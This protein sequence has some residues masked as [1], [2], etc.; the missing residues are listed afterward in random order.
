[1]AASPTPH[2]LSQRFSEYLRG[3]CRVKPGR[4][5]LLACSGGPD[6]MVLAHLLHQIGQPF[7]MAHAQFGLRGQDSAADEVLVRQTAE[8]W[9]LPFYRTALDAA[10][11]ANSGPDSLQMAARD[12]R[13]AWLESIRSAHGYHCIATAHHAD[14]TAE[15]LYMRL[16]TGS[17]L[18]G[19]RGIRPK[20]DRLVRPLLFARKQELL[21]YATAHEV[22]WREDRSN[23]EADYLRNRVRREALPQ[24]ES[25]L[26]GAV[27]G[28]I[29]SASLL[30]EAEM[31]YET[32]LNHWRRLVLRPNQHGFSLALTALLE[33]GAARTLL[34]EFLL[35][36]GFSGAQVDEIAAQAKGQPGASWPSP[37][38]V[39]Y[40][41]RGKLV[42]VE[43]RGPELPLPVSVT[44]I[45]CSVRCGRQRF[46]FSLVDKDHLKTPA[47]DSGVLMDAAA[48]AFPLLIRPW[49]EGD[50]FHP[51]TSGK[52]RKLKR[53]LSDQKI[54]SHQ[55][56]QQL[57][58]LSGER[59]AW[60]VG[61][62]ADARFVSVKKPMVK[63]SVSTD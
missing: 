53:F 10:A 14:D 4:P 55:K 12:L 6:S 27:N 1:M 28:F 51:A 60:V 31:L 58:L 47:A 57:V 38:G 56:S 26:P 43:G 8:Q 46:S 54:P 50:Y 25:L 9:S 16:L 21:D 24:A 33:S 52:K 19:L 13:Y 18:R 42:W 29:R 32:G 39:L 11:L 35:P 23:L 7:G 15:T 2:S 22:P 30:R 41:E 37:D 20:R 61:Y 62:S 3:V 45:P 59:I 5:V 36:L 48:L 63:I 44:T 49:K 17:G 34:R 40:R